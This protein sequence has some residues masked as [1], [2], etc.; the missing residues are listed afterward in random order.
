MTR[1]Q[2]LYVA[3]ACK[4]AK[5]H[6]ARHKTIIDIY[7]QYPNKSSEYKITLNDPWC[8]AFVSEY[9]EICKFC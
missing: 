7:N 8:A 4:G 9:L 6:T 3:N 1:E 5:E 2:I